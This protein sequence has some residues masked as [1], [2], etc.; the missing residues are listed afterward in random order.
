[1]IIHDMRAHKL[2]FILFIAT[3][4]L[5]GEA[6]FG[7]GLS[8]Q[9]V[10][11]KLLLSVDKL[12]PGDGFDLAVVAVVRDGYHIGAHDKDSLY[13]AKLTLSA[14]RGVKFGE[15]IYPSAERKVF[16][17]A[18]KQKLPVYEGR[19]VIRVKGQVAKGLKPGPVEIISKLDTQ[20][21]KDNMC[22]PPQVSQSKLNATVARPGEPIKRVNRD[23]FAA[24]TTGGD[25]AGALAANLE[26]MHWWK[27]LLSLYLGGILLA[28]TPCVYPMIPVTV[29]YFSNQSGKKRRVVMLAGAY[30]LGLALTYSALGA[31]A[32]VTGGV[33]GALM[34]SPIVIAGIALVLVALALSMF[35]LYE[36]QAPGFIQSRSS[37]RSGALGALVMGL[38]FGAVA[39]PCVGPFVL[40]LLILVAKIGNPLMGFLFFF[41]L[42]LGLGTPLFLL[43]V[44]SA[45]MPVPGM[46]MVAV[47]KIAGFL[48]LG[49]AA[50]FV[51]PLLPDAIGRYAIPAVILIAGIYLG[52]FEESIK[53]SRIGSSLGK[54]GSVAAVATA[55]VMV[56][57][58]A[59]HPSLKWEPYTPA[60]LAQ[61]AAEGKPVM[62]DFTA[63]WCAAC[64]ELEHGPFSDPSVINAASD[65]VKLQV[66]G[67]D[68]GSKML[69]DAKKRFGMRTQTFPV[70]VF[71]D[72]TGH[73]V[74]QVRVTGYVD[75]R[76]M[77]RRISEVK[78]VDVAGVDLRGKAR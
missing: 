66:D 68:A 37:G 71:L 22:Y 44:F 14:P 55:V 39:A 25:A 32:A 61:A 5:M 38:L 13:P 26:K 64:H 50:Y 20:A 12:R 76:E 74:K 16:P 27:R 11:S 47:R 43:A 2:R 40:G 48:L 30:L 24:G 6:C 1:M 78:S 29:G 42:S 62:I 69:L 52:F 63:D 18:P 73:E 10:S 34:Q 19:F 31:L 77:I 45:K 58:T 23:V 51:E 57:P 33:F 17:F 72:A 4:T 53:A 35:G 56:F 36:L 49:A 9:A 15:P 28:F 21:C 59:H 41:A 60:K 7:F 46:W 67:T 70:I 54:L 65:F 3:L 8:E 75:S